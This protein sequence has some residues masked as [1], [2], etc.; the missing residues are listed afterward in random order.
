VATGGTYNLPAAEPMKA[1]HTFDGWSD[2]ANTYI[3]GDSITPIT[4]NLTLTAQWT[5]N[6][7]T[8]MVDFDNGDLDSELVV[9]NNM[10]TLPA[11]AP[12][13][14]GYTFTGWLASDGSTYAPGDSMTIIDDLTLTAQWAA[15]DYDVMFALNGG[16]LLPGDPAGIDVTF[17]QPYGTLPEPERVGYDFDRWTLADGT[18]VDEL[19]TVNTP[20]DH[21]LFA[22]WN[23]N[24]YPAT[25]NFNDGA[26]PDETINVTFA[27]PYGTLPAAPARTSY[28]FRGWYTAQTGGTL[29]EDTTIVSTAGAHTLFA[30]WT[31]N[32]YALT[33]IDGSGSGTY[34]SGTVVQIVAD[35]AP[36]GKVFDKWVVEEGTAAIDDPAA[37]TANLTTAEEKA[38]VRA[39]YVSVLSKKTTIFTTKYE[40]NIWNWIMFIFFFGWIWMWFVK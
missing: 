7:Y 19:T 26:T 33:V 17:G 20:D 18:T 31:R 14:P 3:P 9:Y 16:S 39:I 8:V 21:E 38:T 37:S 15:K 22:Q 30:R 27:S 4:S 34:P 35:A 29:V 23:A 13:K 2:S 40:S 6:E 5:L 25:F 1:G 32:E 28:T 10:F 12:E 36:F 24:D 11:T